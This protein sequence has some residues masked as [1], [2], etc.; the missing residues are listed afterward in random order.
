M[1]ITPLIIAE[2]FDSKELSKYFKISFN[3]MAY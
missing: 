1:G 3:H 2:N